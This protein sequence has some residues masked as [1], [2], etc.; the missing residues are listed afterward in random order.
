M[1]HLDI[2]PDSYIVPD[3]VYE[4][5]IP[6]ILHMIWVG[7]EPPA[8]FSE[9]ASQWHALMPSWT[10][11]VWRN[12]DIHTGE[13]PEPIVRLIGWTNKGAQKADIM[14]YHIMEKYGGVYVDA[15]V[16]PRRSLEDLVVHTRRRV[17]LCHDL[18]VTWP[19]I[20]IGFFAAVPNHPL[21]KT[22]CALCY[23]ITVNTS[24][25]HLQSGPR[26]LGKAVWKTP[27]EEPYM[28][29]PIKYFY[30]NDTCPY[31]FGTHTYAKNW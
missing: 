12:E 5:I 17:I 19:Y 2:L 15:D 27:T 29:L 9:H 26:L 28:L 10:I 3:D 23:T 6:R 4:P 1:E 18:P 8:S 7:P 14:R 16:I 21:F 24:D 31:A 13:F 30:R 11:R 20:S 22:A 25:I